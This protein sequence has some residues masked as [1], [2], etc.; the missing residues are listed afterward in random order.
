MPVAIAIASA[1][2]IYHGTWLAEEP[3]PMSRLPYFENKTAM[4]T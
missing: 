2:V 4:K 3:Q 1:D